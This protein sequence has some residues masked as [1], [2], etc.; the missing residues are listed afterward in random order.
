M[1]EWFRRFASEQGVSE[2]EALDFELC[3]NEL[4]SNI[5]RHGVADGRRHE[6]QLT[7]ERSGDEIRAVL[8][9]DGRPFDPAGAE[10]LEPAGSLEAARIGGWGLPIVRAL[11]ESLSYER[12][13]GRNRLTVVARTSSPGSGR[14]ES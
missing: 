10:A 8:E 13:D 9:D 4:F 6:I 1:S 5:V 12:R 14:G 2:A 3:L 7:L 11:T